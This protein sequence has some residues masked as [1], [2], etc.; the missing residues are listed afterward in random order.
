MTIVR[1]AQRGAA[2]LIML[3]I[4]GLGASWLIVSKLN[5]ETGGVEAVRKKRN[6]EVLNRAKQAL[7]GYIAAQAA[8]I[9]ENNPG[10]MPCPEDPGSFGS[11]TTDGTVGAGCASTTIGRFPWRTLG[12]EKFVDASGEPLWYVVG[13]G[14]GAAPLLGTNT[15]INSNSVGQLM[16]DGVANAAVALLIAPGPTISTQARPTTGTPSIANYLEGDNVTAGDNSFVTA[17]ASGSFN[18]QVL[19]IT[20]ADV[21]P[22]IEAAIAH[23]IEKE[24]APVFQ[25][26]YAAPN[27]GLTGTDRVFPYAATFGNPE[28]ANHLGI[29]GKVDG[30][31][32]LVITETFPGSNV[33]CTAGP[34]APRCNPNLM[35][36][37]NAAPSATY[38]NLVLPV[39]NACSYAG[40]SGAALCWGTYAGVG[41]A[42]SITIS[43]VQGN[44]AMALRQINKAAT[45]TVLIIDPFNF[46]SVVT[47]TTPA[48]TVTLNSDGTFTVSVTVTPPAPLGLST[49]TYAIWVP[50]NATSDHSLLDGRASNQTAVATSWFLRNGWDKL[51]YYMVAPGFTAV[52][53]APRSCATGTTCLSIANITPAGSRAAL[54]LA[55]RSVNGRARPSAV[56]ADYYEFG[57][58]TGAFERQTISPFNGIAHVDGGAANAYSIASI[59]A[60]QTGRPFVFAAANANTG[61]ST[62]S[63]PATGL[64]NLVNSDGSA[65]A[66]GTIQ[67]NAVVQ[68]YYDGVQFLLAKRPFNDRIAVLDKN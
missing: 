42:P 8:K 22:A 44:G 2:L 35:N 68:V 40:P 45:A 25:S 64:K 60:L 57:N 13:P 30:L 28:T 54:V 67:A 51:V 65:L 38:S 27:W 24:I 21:L 37:S 5:S 63:T 59:A 50:N 55:G 15:I 53:P 17:G 62:L 18:D 7:I 66:A 29:T 3:G 61:A 43:G 11:T 20:V 46:A 4:I 10:A 1:G 49:V 34:A 9:N 32:P 58:A 12:T 56:R 16:V 19:T 48:P 14:W 39:T 6:A 31:L 41:P 23:R 36:W 26:T 52:T 33:T 47:T